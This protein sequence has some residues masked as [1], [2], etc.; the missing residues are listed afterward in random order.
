MYIRNALQ[1]L[2]ARKGHNLVR[3]SFAWFAFFL[4]D[5]V[6]G[7]ETVPTASI[8]AECDERI[9]GE[10]NLNRQA[11][12]HFKKLPHGSDRI[13]YRNGDVFVGSYRRGK[14][15]GYGTY[16]YSEGGTYEGTFLNDKRHGLGKMIHED[17]QIFVGMY[18]RDK[19]DGKGIL[20]RRNGKIIGKGIWRDGLFV[21]PCP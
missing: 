9:G 17:G 1:L 4:G 19:K 3:L 10:F 11:E 5:T 12:L 7:N 8:A 14:K 20:Y 21:R 13:F 15:N 2:T 6:E 18:F 16:Y